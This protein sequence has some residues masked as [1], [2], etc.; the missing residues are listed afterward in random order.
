MKKTINKILICVLSFA[1]VQTVVPFRVSA[2]D[3]IPEAE[4]IIEE[5]IEETEETEE[6]TAEVIG[7]AEEQSEEIPEDTDPPEVIIEEPAVSETE[8]E[9]EAAY[10]PAEDGIQSSNT[11][12]T[13]I[14]LEANKLQLIT[15]EK[16]GEYTWVKFTP[17]ETARYYLEHAY[18]M[19][20]PRYDTA[21]EMYDGK[22]NLLASDDDT[23]MDFNFCLSRI[24]EAGTTYYYKTHF[25][26]SGTGSFYVI[27]ARDN[28]LTLIP[29][30]SRKRLVAYGGSD[31][32]SVKAY[33]E[34]VNNLTIEWTDGNYNRL[35]QGLSYDVTNVTKY[36]Y[37]LATA[38]DRF[39]NSETCAFEVGVDN[40]FNAFFEQPEIHATSY[41]GFTYELKPVVE[42]KDKSGMT[43]EWSNEV[44]NGTEWVGQGI[45]TGAA[46]DTLRV[47]I[48]DFPV[49][50]TCH[51]TDRYG[52]YAQPQVTIQTHEPGDVVLYSHR[53][54]VPYGKTLQ[55]Y[56]NILVN[57]SVDDT[58]VASVN[59]NSAVTGKKVGTTYIRAVSRE[60]SSKSESRRLI[61]A[62]TD[63]ANESA[64]YFEPVYWAV[65]D[66]ITTGTSPTTFSPNDTCTREQIVT[67][68]WRMMGQ[69][70]PGKQSN[71]TDVSKD[72]WYYKAISWAAEHGITTGLN[73]GT[74]RFGV[75][76][77][78]TREQCVTFLYRAVEWY[79]VNHRLNNVRRYH[80]FSD[81]AKGK[82]Y[83][84]AVMWAY[85]KDITTGLN[86]GTGRFG[87][88]Q[89]C[90]RAMIVTFLYR[91]GFYL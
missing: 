50:Y 23:G 15:V 52:N 10:G 60:D 32:L 62:F 16:A 40:G 86:D 19:Y 18:D 36:G 35:G 68:L 88:G 21:V 76:Q 59:A 28:M 42:A 51:I 78:C 87:V 38:T 91:C 73:D 81:V 39:G 89:K 77:P 4:E 9:P 25:F 79:D 34:D 83:S 90:T 6:L 37:I 70:E 80:L 13:A 56:S 47:Q 61:V 2:E 55:L 43:Y 74:G 3:D 82:Y 66:S 72:K 20:G 67:F 71:F 14:N 84:D 49:R 44:Y 1:L 65:E 69:P 5:V 7:E 53:Y 41:D 58:S 46:T 33:A 8:E 29:V 30:G 17:K 57:W 48:R 63:A 45:I 75:G 26:G 54:V 31:R 85:D 11:M 27:L 22:G 12:A 64:Y 24:L